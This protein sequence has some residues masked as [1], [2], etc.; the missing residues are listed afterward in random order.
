MERVEEFKM[1]PWK[2]AP[3]PANVPL[4]VLRPLPKGAN[5]AQD[6]GILFGLWLL[7]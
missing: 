5:F 3:W 4:P 2:P 7:S 1:L 6:A